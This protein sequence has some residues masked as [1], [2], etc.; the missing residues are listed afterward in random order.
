VLLQ[1]VPER[2]AE[3]AFGEPARAA[4]AIRARG[5]EQLGSV[6]VVIE[7]LR[8]RARRLRDHDRDK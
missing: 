4:M 7:V 6:F 2:D 8:L 1:V 5:G 3:P